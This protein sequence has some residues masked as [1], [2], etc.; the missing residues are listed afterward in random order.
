MTIEAAEEMLNSLKAD[1]AI[2]YA[3][4]YNNGGALFAEIPNGNSGENTP[5][6]CVPPEEGYRIEK[7]VCA[8]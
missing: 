7:A 5:P 6:S 8:Y 2:I 1:P 3:A 4:V